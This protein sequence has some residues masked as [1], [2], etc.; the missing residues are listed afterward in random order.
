MEIRRL[1]R[2]TRMGSSGGLVTPERRGHQPAAV[3]Q[4]DS[5]DEGSEAESE[6]DDGLAIDRHA[7]ADVVLDRLVALVDVMRTRA[8]R[9]LEERGYSAGIRVLGPGEEA[10]A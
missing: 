2:L 3:Q 6:S 9:S 7:E 5:E 4:S 8:G 10:R 1:R